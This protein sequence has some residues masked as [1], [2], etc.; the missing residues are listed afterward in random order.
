MNETLYAV[1]LDPLD[2]SFD[3]IAIREALRED[4]RI[5]HWWNHIPNCFLVSTSRTAAQLSSW[6]KR[7]SGEVGFLVIEVNPRNSEGYLPDRSW[8]WIKKREQEQAT[9]AA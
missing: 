8:N 7:V 2:P 6:L 1:F 3:P 4:G 5:S 9:A